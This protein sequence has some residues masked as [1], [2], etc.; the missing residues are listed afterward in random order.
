MECNWC[1]IVENVLKHSMLQPFI[2]DH[3]S[4]DVVSYAHC[5]LGIA[6]YLSYY[7]SMVQSKP[8]YLDIGLIL[9]FAHYQQMLHFSYI[10]L[11]L[12]QG[13]Q[14]WKLGVKG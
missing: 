4:N 8:H 11:N 10:F 1:K 3:A 2:K 12:L 9:N 7:V 13:R 14:R 5:L 6:F